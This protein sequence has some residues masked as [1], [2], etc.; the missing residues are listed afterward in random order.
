MCQ[1]V[2]VDIK[3]VIS[4][5]F[6]RY[7]DIK[8]RRVSVNISN[9][10]KTVTQTYITMRKDAPQRHYIEHSFSN[11]QQWCIATIC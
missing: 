6:H 11:A 9:D 8:T 3:I 7:L 2:R 4:I 5:D 1:C 10:T